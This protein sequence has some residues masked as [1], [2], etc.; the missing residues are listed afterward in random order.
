MSAYEEIRV[1]IGA[2]DIENARVSKIAL[3][4][5]M[6]AVNR[7][8]A[9]HRAEIIR[10][11]ADEITSDLDA[12]TDVVEGILRA[13]GNYFTDTN[14]VCKGIWALAQWLRLKTDPFREETRTDG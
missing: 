6:P 3:D 9:E 7:I 1:A 14:E 13:N 11:L 5:V 10:E 8:L 2:S 12:V 4:A